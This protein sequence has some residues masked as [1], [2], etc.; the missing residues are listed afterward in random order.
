MVEILRSVVIR[1]R[2]LFCIYVAFYRFMWFVIFSVFFFVCHVLLS[3]MQLFLPNFQSIISDFLYIFFL[4]VK[5][6]V[7][8]PS[9]SF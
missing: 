7:L 6:P 4:I 5:S 1:L 2:F 8:F 9:L 3:S